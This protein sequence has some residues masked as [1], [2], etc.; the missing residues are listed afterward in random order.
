MFILGGGGGYRSRGKSRYG[1]GIDN[2]VRIVLLGKTGSGK[3]ATGNTILNGDFF[4]STTSGSSITSRCTSRHAQRFGKEIQIVDTPGVFD[5]NIPNHVVQREIMY[6][7]NLAR[8]SL[9]PLSSGALSFYTR[10]ERVHRSFCQL[11][12]KKGI[13]LFHRAFYEKR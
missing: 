13:S 9:F 11:F 1:K 7:N 4:E 3:S 8:S 10:R 2:E 6:R 5:T 12:W